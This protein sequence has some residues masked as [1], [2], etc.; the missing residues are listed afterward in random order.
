MRKN[1][2]NWI[3][4]SMGRVKLVL[5][6]LYGKPQVLSASE[7]MGRFSIDQI[8]ALRQTLPTVEVN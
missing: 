4:D 7:I 5:P 2:A 8:V 6:D 1:Q 3:I